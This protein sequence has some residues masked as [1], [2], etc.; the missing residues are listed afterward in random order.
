MGEP[1][2]CK[3]R[4]LTPRST[5]SS[6]S[7]SI[8]PASVWNLEDT[9][10]PYNFLEVG[11][12]EKFFGEKEPEGVTQLLI[13]VLGWADWCVEDDI[14]K[15]K[16]EYRE[17]AR[18]ISAFERTLSETSVKRVFRAIL[19][20]FDIDAVDE[21][22]N[23]LGRNDMIIDSANGLHSLVVE[24][25]SGGANAH[26][27]MINCRLQLLAYMMAL[28]ADNFKKAKSNNKNSD[29]GTQTIIGLLHIGLTPIFYKAKFTSAYVQFLL[30]FTDKNRD[31]NEIIVEP[32]ELLVEWYN[33]S[34]CR[35]KFTDRE[36]LKNRATKK[37]LKCYNALFNLEKQLSNDKKKFDQL[38]D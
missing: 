30:R 29:I 31:E 28:A 2:E 8:K 20:L 27:K 12:F 34:Q 38:T 24:N 36:L 7:S 18:A 19:N 10:Y 5:G 1:S 4:K 25:K 15:I 23:L 6:K 14:T 17:I 16:Q 35:Y 37:I 9:T 21:C 22:T 26:T 11:S 13:E 33:P 32:E 3:K